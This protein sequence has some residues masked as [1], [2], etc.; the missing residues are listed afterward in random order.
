[1][2]AKALMNVP[3]PSATDPDAVVTALEMAQLFHERGDAPE[4]IR[5]LRR[6]A[7]SAV[8]HGLDMRAVAL[9]RAAAEL[10]ENLNGAAP[11]PA[12]ASD[13]GELQSS[14]NAASSPVAAPRPRRLPDP[15]P[16]PVL[17]RQVE[18]AALDPEATP[19]M[20][21]HASEALLA[22][23][24]SPRRSAPPPLPARDSRRPEAEPTPAPPRASVPPRASA[25]PRASLTP[26]RPSAAPPPT[27]PSAAPRSNPSAAPA[28]R[29]A[30]SARSSIAPAPRPTSAGHPQASSEAPR[31]Q[32]QQ[33]RGRAPAEHAAVTPIPRGSIA[34]AASVAPATSVVP[35]PEPV[36]TRPSLTVVP[37][38]TAAR[39]A[40]APAPAA[41]DAAQ[42]SAVRVAVHP[43]G[44]GT[45]L[46]EVLPHG[47]E[48]PTGSHEATLVF[49]RGPVSL[50][51]K[52]DQ[53]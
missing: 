8:D 40:E 44:A 47:E 25:P 43:A 19:I 3:E 16:R 45:F 52:R 31:A 21:P 36:V 30:T 6:A 35:A 20:P 10:K 22:N 17:A 9:A 34:P 38:P 4:A 27:S 1:M 46:V 32:T 42:C 33:A 15:P 53:D 49:T 26:A 29:Q 11:A 41:P 7:E 18:H 51:A 48:P 5:W 14:P 24:P 23:E 37:A 50:H 28:P 12:P 39:V 13:K 2:E